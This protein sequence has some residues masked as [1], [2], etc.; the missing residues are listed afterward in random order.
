M[1]LN[2]RYDYEFI[3]QV[4]L[5]LWPTNQNLLLASLFFEILVI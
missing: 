2:S 5:F 1:L 3:T 4:I